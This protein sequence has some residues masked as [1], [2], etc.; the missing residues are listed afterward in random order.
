MRRQIDKS[1]KGLPPLPKNDD[2][3]AAANASTVNSKKE[4]VE[5]QTQ[6][7]LFGSI[8]SKA[9]PHKRKAV[10]DG[11]DDERLAGKPI[12]AAKKKPKKADKKLLSFGDES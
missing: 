8:G 5:K 10:G 6:G 7:L 4:T 9:K 1:A 3:E 12:K 2:K 11:R